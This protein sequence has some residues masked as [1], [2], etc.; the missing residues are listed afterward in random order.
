MVERIRI[1]KG[2]STLEVESYN[3]LRFPLG[4]I[5]YEQN[6]LKDFDPNFTPDFVTFV[7]RAQ[8]VLKHSN[9]SSDITHLTE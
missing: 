5:V 2:N 6:N 9:T 3:E 1:P 8:M 4:R 7:N